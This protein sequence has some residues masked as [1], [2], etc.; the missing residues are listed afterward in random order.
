MERTL[1]L[2]T[3]EA[4]Y[5]KVVKQ[6]EAAGHRVSLSY[7]LF[8]G[9]VAELLKRQ[10]EYIQARLALLRA[11]IAESGEGYCAECGE[12]YSAL[13]LR[14]VY[15]HGTKCIGSSTASGKRTTKD[16]RE[17]L[18]L[19]KVCYGRNMTWSQWSQVGDTRMHT[20]SLFEEVHVYQASFRVKDMSNFY[21][22]D[23]GSEI[24]VPEDA[25]DL[26]EADITFMHKHADRYF[27]PVYIHYTFND[28]ALSAFTFPVFTR[29]DSANRDQRKTILFDPPKTP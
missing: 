15:R 1:D 11:R 6:F 26:R 5:W 28:Y 7:Q 20:E 25:A 29:A 19:C 22:S 18:Y 21:F 4:E 17:L 23:D 3:I 9:L 13:A 16:F 14:T 27:L 10:E 2:T 12:T 24:D 8:H